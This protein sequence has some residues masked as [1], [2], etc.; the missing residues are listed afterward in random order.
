[1]N[2]WPWGSELTLPS[3]TRSG[4][5]SSD[6]GS[7]S[8]QRRLPVTVGSDHNGGAYERLPFY[9]EGPLWVESGRRI[10]ARF[11]GSARA[12]I[13]SGKRNYRGWTAAVASL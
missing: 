13:H 6:I 9:T 7:V 8:G 1:M 2:L 10:V 3:V 4:L 5:R 12:N 11:R